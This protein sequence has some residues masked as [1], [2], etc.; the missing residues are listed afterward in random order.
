MLTTTFNFPPHL[1]SL[2]TTWKQTEPKICFLRKGLSPASV[3]IEI[4]LVLLL[5]KLPFPQPR[6]PQ[7]YD[8]KR[9]CTS[10]SFLGLPLLPVV[11]VPFEYFSL[12]PT[13]DWVWSKTIF[14]IKLLHCLHPVALRVITSLR[15][16]FVHAGA[17][18]ISGWLFHSPSPFDLCLPSFHFW[19]RREVFWA[20]IGSR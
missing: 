17:A 4:Q 16:I 11:W 20:M 9:M 13:W 7:I 6:S 14:I 15:L 12:S 2:S 18:R 5:G 8:W 3:L 1:N 10:G 19:A